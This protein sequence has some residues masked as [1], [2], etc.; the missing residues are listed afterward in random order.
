MLF[1]VC[2]QGREHLE[3][4]DA[5]FSGNQNETSESSSVRETAS[6]FSV[7]SSLLGKPKRYNIPVYVLLPHIS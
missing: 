6:E 5:G 1:S 4:T 7:K 2:I 3:Q